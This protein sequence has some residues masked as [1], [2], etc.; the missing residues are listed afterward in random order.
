MSPR[1]GS[2]SWVA[3]LNALDLDLVTVTGDL[4]T[5]GARTSRPSRG[6]WGRCARRTASSP[7]WATTTTSPTASPS[8]ASWSAGLTVL[9]NRGVVMRRGEPPLRGRRRRHLDR[10]RRRGAGARERPRASPPCC[11][12]TTPTCSPRPAHG[13]E[14][15]LSGHT[16]GGQL[17]A[18]GRASPLTGAAHH[19]LHGGALPAGPLVAL[20]EPRRSARP[21][22]RCGLGALAGADG[23]HPR[24]ARARLTAR[25]PSGGA[26]HPA[27][28]RVVRLQV[29]PPRHRRYFAP[30]SVGGLPG[31]EEDWA[32]RRTRPLLTL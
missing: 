29:R 9:R 28:R 10:P 12:R 27:G 31:R 25:A 3:R 24:R 20:R 16:H 21:D 22:R 1:T 18:P 23:H 14:L 6:R 17:A 7:A 4:I 8:R 26:R 11:S 30:A 15:T 32:P 5:H 13:V 19:P 2:A